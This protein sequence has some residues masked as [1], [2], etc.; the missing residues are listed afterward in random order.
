MTE[1]EKP[2][3]TKRKRLWLALTALAALLALL[4]V[5]PFVSVSRYKARIT[6]L[7]STSLGRPARLSSVEVRLLPRP[8]FVLSDLTVEEDP[9]YGTEPVLHANSVSASI[10]LLSLWR[11]HIELDSISVDEASL[12]LVRT[13]AGRWNLDSLLRTATTRAQFAPG[14]NQAG[15][16]AKLDKLDKPVKLPY[17]EATNSRI[18]IKNGAEKLPFSL[19]DAKFSL[20][21]QSPS[22]WRVQLRGQPARTDLSIGQADTGV[23]RLTAILHQAPELR[24]IPLRVD[25]EW[26]EAQ[27]GQL[28]RLVLGSDAGWRGDLTGQLHLEGTADMAQVKTRLRATDV[29]R[30]EFAPA[31]PMDFDAN[32]AF[33]AH[34]S[35][36]AIDNLICDSPLGSGRI[37]VNGNLP[38]QGSLPNFSIELER[39]SVAAALD[40]LRSVRSGF[41]PGLD[42]A[43][44]A[45]GKL[46]FSPLAPESEAPPKPTRAKSR[47]AKDHPVVGPLTGSLTVTGLQFSG[48]GLNQPVVIPELVLTPVPAVIDQQQAL[49]AT[50]AIPAGGASPLTV[51]TRLALSGYQLT[52]HGQASISRGRELARAAGLANA[53]SLDTLAGDPVTIDLTAEGPWMRLQLAI[54]TQLPQFPSESGAISAP[55]DTLAGTLVLHNANWKAEFLANSILISQATLHLGASTLRWDPVV[56][57]YGPVKGT[58][59]LSIPVACEPLKPCLPAF[60][61]QFGALDAAVVQTTF[62]GAHEKDTL[63]STLIERLRPAAALTWPQMNGTIKAESLILGPV[64][65]RNPEASVS[66]LSNGAEINAFDATLLGGR[67]HASG[68]YHAAVTAKDKPLY[69]L[70]G[71]FDKLSPTLVGQLLGLRSTGGTFNG[72]GK[73]ALSGFT[74][75]DLSASAKGTLNFEWQ[76]GMIAGASGIPPAL[77]HFD[78]WNGVA[79]IANGALTLHENQVKHTG[80]TDQV[81]A[82]VT[83]TDPPKVAFTIPKAAPAKP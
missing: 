37:R 25:L 60:Q 79:A 74:G 83:L 16:F 14:I 55:A 35:I 11:G 52:V 3:Q 72:N 8:G 41:A 54:Q 47:F 2:W 67:V 66:T 70:E 21:Q 32:C 48:S 12:N 10:R 81:Q 33:V 36:R 53:L 39:V 17:L 59:S 22:D 30:V 13:P 28:T 44:S 57:S 43:G 23:V 65:L 24:Q 20:E 49:T 15:D 27:L 63:L 40:A 76:R 56:F 58:A 42:A 82:T 68:S 5:P 62:L 34:F 50:T 4:I 80:H 6:Q 73:I 71:Q 38:G 7:I 75:D 51:S 19:I 78:R 1:D 64:T 69:E 61:V 29:H 18:N 46:S 45:S 26:R 77:A 9:A 31:E